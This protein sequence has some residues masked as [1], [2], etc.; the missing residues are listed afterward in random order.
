MKPGTTANE[1]VLPL[2]RDVTS[3]GVITPKLPANN[4]KGNGIPNLERF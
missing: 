2:A 4:Q 3:L 1:G